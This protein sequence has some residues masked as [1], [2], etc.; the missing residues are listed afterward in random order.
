MDAHEKKHCEAGTVV[1]MRHTGSY[2]EIG[3]VYHEL[4]Q[5]A[6]EKNVEVEG[7]GRT[8]FLDPPSEFDPQSSVFEVCLPVAK[9][10]AGDEKVD[11]KELPACTIASFVV[12]GPYSEIPAHYA[13]AVAWLSAE[14][15]EIAGPPSEVYVKR[16]DEHGHG[17]PNEFVTE[18]QFPIRD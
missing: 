9:G 15:W 13:E 10:T 7:R 5:W 3:K 1:S 17:D 14:G 18:I 8:I 2:D 11:V 16:P 12:K 6:R 4:Y